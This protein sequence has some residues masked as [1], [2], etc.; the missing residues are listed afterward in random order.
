MS[1]SVSGLVEFCA[2]ASTIGNSNIVGSNRSKAQR[3]NFMTDP[4]FVL[5]AFGP[6]GAHF[7]W[8]RF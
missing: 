6:G 2:N 3:S 8:I 5:L 7:F 1:Q 4:L